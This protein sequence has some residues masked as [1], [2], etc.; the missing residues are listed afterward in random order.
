MQFQ[1]HLDAEKPA[2]LR[3]LQNT[4]TLMLLFMLGVEREEMRWLKF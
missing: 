1:G 2:F 3:L 4:L